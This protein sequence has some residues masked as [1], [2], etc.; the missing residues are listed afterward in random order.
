MDG[1]EEIGRGTPGEMEREAEEAQRYQNSDFLPK[2][3]KL[4]SVQKF[5]FILIIS[6]AILVQLS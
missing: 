1:F 2:K 6:R 5:C 3:K 4:L